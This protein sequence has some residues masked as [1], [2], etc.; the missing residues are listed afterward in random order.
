MKER[1]QRVEREVIEILGNLQLGINL[2]QD[3]FINPNP[4]TRLLEKSK[5]GHKDRRR[6][7][8]FH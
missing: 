8:A 1:C 6:N 2:G 5:T 3:S 7:Q 4:V